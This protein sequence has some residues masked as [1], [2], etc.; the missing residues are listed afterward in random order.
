MREIASL[1][2]GLVLIRDTKQLLNRQMNTEGLH[3]FDSTA[4]SVCENWNI[5]THRVTKGF[6]SRGKTGKG[7]FYGFKL[8]GARDAFGNLENVRFTT[9]SEHDSRQAES[10]TEG[11]CGLFIEAG[12]IPA[13]V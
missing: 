4:L 12:S 1:A 6:A 13:S 9:G 7:W 3:F 10:L 11:L 8:H 5:A 2:F